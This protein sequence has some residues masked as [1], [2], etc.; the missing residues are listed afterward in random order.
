MSRD[1]DRLDIDLS[2]ELIC[3]FQGWLV[4]VI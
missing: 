3:V 4:T 1:I 2:Q